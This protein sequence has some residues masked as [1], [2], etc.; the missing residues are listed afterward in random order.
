MRAYALFATLALLAAPFVAAPVGEA[1]EAFMKPWE[2]AAAALAARPGVSSAEARLGASGIIFLEVEI[3]H[4]AVVAGEVS[5]LDTGLTPAML[6]AAPAPFQFRV[7]VPALG[8][9][10][11]WG[12]YDAGTGTWVGMATHAQIPHADLEPRLDE[13]SGTFIV[14]LPAEG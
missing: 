9:R 4:E 14:A 10:Y 8:G 3:D 1:E 12:E 11:W 13:A 5:T 6:A 2:D 7:T